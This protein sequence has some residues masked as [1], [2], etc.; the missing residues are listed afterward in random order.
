VKIC[1]AGCKRLKWRFK[2]RNESE[3][4]LKRKVKIDS[5]SL[6]LLKLYEKNL[7][8]LTFLVVIV[9]SRDEGIERR[10]IVKQI[11]ES[12]NLNGKVKELQIKNLI[13]IK[14][15]YEN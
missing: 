15:G 4:T 2:A 1:R 12:I 3:E 8:R 5:E 14:N 10:K 11:L 6:R 9:R 7:Y 13:N